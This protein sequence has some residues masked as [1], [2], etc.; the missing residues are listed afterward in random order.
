MRS[1]FCRVQWRAS[2]QAPRGEAIVVAAP[3]ERTASDAAIRQPRARARKAG[4]TKRANHVSEH[5]PLS[6]ASTRGRQKDVDA[7]R[8]RMESEICVV[9][10]SYEGALVGYSVPASVCE[11]ISAPADAPVAPVFGFN[12]HEGCIRSVATGGVLLATSGTDNTIGV[13]NLR[14]RRSYGKLTQQQ[15]GATTMV[16]RF[17]G[18]SHLVSGGV[19]TGI[20]N[21]PARPC[22]PAWPP[23]THARASLRRRGRRSEHLANVGLGVPDT[24]QRA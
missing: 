7:R 21:E 2:G 11:G 14:K 5:R 13:Y 15:G 4:R 23:T 20:M 24:G 3:I 9:A 17:F 18:D 1:A 19:R 22:S 8:G 6:P 10:G 12:A 16:M